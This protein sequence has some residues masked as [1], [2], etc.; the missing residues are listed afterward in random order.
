MILS[1]LVF[2]ATLG[3][4]GL[5]NQFGF[6]VE[7][8]VRAESRL[9][10]R[11]HAGEIA[12]AV[13]L[14]A[15]SGQIVRLSVVGWADL[16]SKRPMK[17]DTIFQVWSMTKP[18]TA[19]AAIIAAEEGLL[20]LDDPVE[21]YF[22]KFRTLQV[23]SGESLVPLARRPTIRHMLSHTSGLSS[24][25][26]GG[27]S[28]E[29]K[30]RMRLADYA[31]LVGT[32]PLAAQPGTKILYCGVGFS[33]VAAIIEKVSGTPF[34]EYVKD[35]IF[36]RLGMNDTDFFLKPE[37]HKRLATTYTS[38]RERLIPF[39]HDPFRT[40]AKFAN[41][42]GGLYSTA[43][44]MMKFI[45]A[46]DPSRPKSILSKRAQDAMCALQTGDLLSD[47]GDE[48]GYGL[49]WSIIRNPS[50]QMQ[51]KPVGTIGHTGA[52]GTEFWL[53]RKSGVAVVF[54]I[55][56][57]GLSDVARKSFSTMVNA[58]FVGP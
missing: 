22:P 26:P 37:R 43:E 47:G 41:G 55:Q 6:E 7:R 10:E 17:A 1:A 46:F 51:L 36:K 29:R 48:R 49:G 44:D 14:V 40:G 27:L 16:E 4:T 33:V 8:L 28:D 30:F 45:S 35:R 23:V 54:M 12:G 9:R 52:F 21:K 3:Q 39:P 42:A 20:N 18:V 24:D 13:A 56:G 5:P 58:A 32:E 57:F 19:A 31:E 50:G 25:D 38:E 11:A 34:Q 15:R 2:S 53:D